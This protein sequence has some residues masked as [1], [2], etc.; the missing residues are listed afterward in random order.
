MALIRSRHHRAAMPVRRIVKSTAADDA[1]AAGSL[2]LSRRG[3]FQAHAISRYRRDVLDRLVRWIGQG[4]WRSDVHA[5]RR[6]ASVSDKDALFFAENPLHM[7]GPGHLAQ[8]AEVAS[9]DHRSHISGDRRLSPQ[10]SKGLV[11][12]PQARNGIEAGYEN[13]P[14][15][16]EQGNCPRMNLEGQID[17]DV[18]VSMRHAIEQCGQS[19]DVKIAGVKTVAA[20]GKDVQSARMTTDK[21]A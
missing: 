14:R 18:R 11:D 3:G 16:R 20:C 4:H 12:L 5:F 17:D 6:D 8:E 9:V 7:V 19:L 13:P 21:S 2:A 15:R 10:G 1:P